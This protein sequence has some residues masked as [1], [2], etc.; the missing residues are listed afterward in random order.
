MH[1]NV[2]SAWQSPA[3]H[4]NVFLPR[5]RLCRPHLAR[6]T[7]KEALPEMMLPCAL[8][9]ASTH[10]NA[11]AVS[12]DPFAVSA[13]RTATKTFPVV[14]KQYSLNTETM[15][16]EP[17][18]LVPPFHKTVFRNILQCLHPSNSNIGQNKILINYMIKF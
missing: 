15:V 5:Q 7:A 9:R 10:G 12:K 17:F 8:C 4:D 13:W 6:R 1:G 11:F 14:L 3:V 18:L 16:P 2:P